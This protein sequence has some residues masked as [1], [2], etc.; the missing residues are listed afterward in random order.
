MAVLLLL[1]EGCANRPERTAARAFMRAW[2]YRTRSEQSF[3]P[4]YL[5][6]ERSA[7]ELPF[8]ARGREI[9]ECVSRL[10][11]WRTFRSNSTP[12]ELEKT[13]A[14]PDSLMNALKACADRLGVVSIQ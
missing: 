3:E 5:D 9:R 11:S 12:E 14:L 1:T 8:D 6:A 4:R 10:D 7:D 2:E 13:D